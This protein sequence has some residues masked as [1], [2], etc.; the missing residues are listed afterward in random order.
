MKKF[1][2][3]EKIPGTSACIK[4]PR[5]IQAV[6]IEEKFSLDIGYGRHQTGEPGD[7]ILIDV[8]GD[9][10]IEPKIVFERNYEWCL[11]SSGDKNL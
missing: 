5:A 2:A 6:R 1:A 4:K 11:K 9:L 10:Y 3:G 8:E 7:Y